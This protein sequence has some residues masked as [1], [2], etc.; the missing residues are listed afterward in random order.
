MLTF[1]LARWCKAPP[2]P[3]SMLGVVGAQR[4]ASVPVEMSV[5]VSSW[6]FCVRGRPWRWMTDF[7][8]DRLAGMSGR[9]DLPAAGLSGLTAQPGQ[10]AQS[11]E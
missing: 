5:A 3:A 9:S 7:G 11:P 4:L 1:L 2:P 10:V 8:Y 6:C